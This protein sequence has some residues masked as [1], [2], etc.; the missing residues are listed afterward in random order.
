MYVK[1]GLAGLAAV[2]LI[3]VILPILV[4]FFAL[5]ILIVR[6]GGAGVGI[7]GPHWHFQ[8]P[9]FWVF[10]LFVF[11]IGYFWERYRLTK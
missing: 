3:F 8:S 11:G 6:H 5:L 1:C 4:V 7:D 9:L 10:A 2:F